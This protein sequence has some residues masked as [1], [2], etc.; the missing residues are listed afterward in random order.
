MLSLDILQAEIAADMEPGV[1]GVLTV[2]PAKVL[3]KKGIPFVTKKLYRYEPN[4]GTPHC[5]GTFAVARQLS[6]L[7][8]TLARQSGLQ[9]AEE[10]APS[11]LRNGASNKYGSGNV[12]SQRSD[13]SE[14]QSSNGRRQEGEVGRENADCSQ[15]EEMAKL[16]SMSNY[17]IDFKLTGSENYYE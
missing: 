16:I 17:K 2:L 15:V 10:V 6:S 7:V 5:D 4:A 1:V 11:H 12:G 14:L 13:A 9:Q 8:N 3:R